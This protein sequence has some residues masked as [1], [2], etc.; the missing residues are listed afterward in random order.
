[1]PEYNGNVKKAFAAES[2]YDSPTT[3]ETDTINF[4]IQEVYYSS[5]GTIVNKDNTL[6]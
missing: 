1:M 5:K 6:R 3:L 4:D 2:F